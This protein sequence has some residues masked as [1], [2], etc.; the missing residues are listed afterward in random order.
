MVD[1][2]HGGLG[3]EV[4]GEGIAEGHAQVTQHLHKTLV[5]R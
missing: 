5:H 1:E 4:D 2:L 3:E